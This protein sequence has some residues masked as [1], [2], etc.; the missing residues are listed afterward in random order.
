MTSL[1]LCMSS[2]DSF[3]DFSCWFFSSVCR[4]TSFSDLSLKNQIISLHFSLLQL[5]LV[6][7]YLF[8]F[9]EV[10]WYETKF[11]VGRVTNIMDLYINENYDKYSHRL[12]NWALHVDNELTE[13]YATRASRYLA[14]VLKN[15][16][17]TR[18]LIRD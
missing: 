4:M 2:C 17:W 1:G 6:I 13:N 7:A 8:N 5:Y 15:N 12:N 3:W 16:S 14:S 18:D 10:E 11:G 9:S